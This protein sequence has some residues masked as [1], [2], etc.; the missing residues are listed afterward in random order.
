[1]ENMAISRLRRNKISI[2]VTG[3]VILSA[4]LFYFAVTPGRIDFNTQVKPILNKNCIV[5]H[6][7]VKRLG[8]FS[9]LFRSEAL[10]VNKSGKPAIIPHDPEHSEI[11]RRLTLKDPEDRM[12]YKQEPLAKKDIDILRQWIKEGAVWGDHWAYVPVKE[13][14][15][16]KPGHSFFGW[17]YKAKPEWVKNDIDYFILKELQENKLTPS[18][19]ADKATLLRRVSFDLVGLPPTPSL[20]KAFLQAPDE[21]TYERLVDSLLASPHFGEKWA[22]MWLDLARYADSQGYEADGERK[23]IWHYRDWL[24]RAFNGDMSYDRFLTEQM[25]GDLLPVKNDDQFIATGFHR[26]SMTNSEGGTDNEE[27]RTAAVLDRVN[28][29]WQAIMGT[30]FACVQC[31]SHPYDPFKHEDYYSFMAFFNDTRDEDTYDDYPLLREFSFSDS[32]KLQ[33]V[34][35]WVKLNGTA[36]EA[37]QQ[38]LFLK[39]WQPSVNSLRAD[40]YVN[41]ALQDTK[42]LVFR[43]HS[44]ARLQQVDLTNRDELIFR[45]E[46]HRKGG[47]L[48]IHLD[49]LDG[50][51]LKKISIDTTSKGWEISSISLPPASGPHDLYLAYSNPLMRNLTDNGLLFDWLHFGKSLPG[52][53]RPGYAALEKTWWELLRKDRAG[54]PVM[55]DNPKDMHRVSNV[56]VRGNWLVKGKTVLPDV[57]H[58]LN[59]FPADAPRNRLG[60]AAWLTDKRNP[61]VA[62]TLINRLWEQLFG[63]GLVETL[64]DMGTQGAA[65]THRELLDCLSWKLMHE[66][67]WS[68]KKCLKEMVMSATYRQ[69]SKFTETLR[70]KDPYNKLYAR[71]P[72]VRLSAEEVRDQ[73]LTAS[74]LLSADMYGPPVM[75][76]QPEGIWLSPYNSNTWK[77]SVGQNQYRRA[78]YTYWKRTAPYPS[79]I[80]FDG[81][82]REVCTARRIR[83]NT[84]LQALVTLNDSVYIEASRHLAFRMMEAYADM[85]SGDK[86]SRPGDKDKMI[87][88]GYELLTFRPIEPANLVILKKLYDKAYAAYSQKPELACEVVGEPGVHAN[89]ETAAC[90]V[91]A[92]ALLNLDEV[93]TKN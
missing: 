93:I 79:M 90:V 36:T 21:K 7:G 55:M 26:N 40:Q 91:V 46:A 18:V 15:I 69:D 10:A 48:T 66:E 3:I 89:P 23:G 11:M 76:W 9:L 32:A 16:P 74:G 58:S 33:S 60:L 39:T 41:S 31:H 62:R 14:E 54:I 52:R 4:L 70:E 22:A 24:I 65:P 43:N 47:S 64:E 87:A 51:V 12:P 75:P 5:C 86:T 38:V 57:P 30:T 34:S 20:A 67:G 63:S 77:T 13:V 78:I 92:G 56:F 82:S 1:M 59:P 27:F 72:R 17:N 85:T 61:L 8:D 28:T 80:T 45:Y 6:G 19:E 37:A 44:S 73:A 29:T 83:T 84:P 49:S 25:A 50:P 42:Y 2:L 35:E 88:K 71:G 53:G 68:I 81:A